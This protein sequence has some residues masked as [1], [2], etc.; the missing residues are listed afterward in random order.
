MSLLPALGTAKS[1]TILSSRPP[2]KAGLVGWPQAGSN[3]YPMVLAM[4]ICKSHYLQNV[5]RSEQPVIL[6]SLPSVALETLHGF[7]GSRRPRKAGWVLV[8][9]PGEL[10]VQGIFNILQ[11]AGRSLLLRP[12]YP[13][14]GIKLS[15]TQLLEA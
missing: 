3:F 8:V 15:P 12:L 13:L 2:K 5:P 10:L 1:V 14:G 9:P 4:N 11:L 7:N 6:S